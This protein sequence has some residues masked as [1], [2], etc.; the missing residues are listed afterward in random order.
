MKG[1]GKGKG[2]NCNPITSK[3]KRG[4][5]MP[6]GTTPGKHPGKTMMMN[7]SNRGR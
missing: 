5:G 2:T 6:T 1:K 4:T 7:K 3:V